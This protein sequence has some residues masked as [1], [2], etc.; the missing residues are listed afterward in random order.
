[1]TRGIVAFSACVLVIA[2]AAGCGSSGP[3]VTLQVDPPSDGSC[4]GVAGFVVTI[5]PAGRDRVIRSLPNPSPI[6]SKATCRLP[7]QVSMDNIGVDLPID[8]TVDGYDSLEQLRVT[9]TLQ[10]P[11]LDSPGERHL[12]LAAAGDTTAAILL[13]DRSAA[14]GGFPLSDVTDFQISAKSQ[15]CANSTSDIVAKTSV[16]SAE[17]FDASP[18]G[19]FAAPA[20]AMA[21]VTAG[22]NV[23]VCLYFGTPAAQSAGYAV[24]LAPD[25][26]WLASPL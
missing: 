15:N 20:A 9:G 3:S 5:K 1:V 17:F 8:V 2:G 12:V 14:L 18:T 19:A 13:V 21:A 7:Q 22:S 11:S 24:G 4:I 26:Y 6:V 16:L 25:G 23:F 10:I